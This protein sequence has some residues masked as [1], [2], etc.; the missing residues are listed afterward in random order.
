[1]PHW[2]QAIEHYSKRISHTARIDL[3]EVKDAAPKLPKNTGTEQ[4][5]ERILKHIKPS[6]VLIC[7]DETGKSMSSEQLATHLGQLYDSGKTPCF[8]I[9][10]AYGHSAEVRKRANLLLSM[11]AMTFPHELAKVILFE[12]I[13]RTETILAGTGYHHQ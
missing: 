11:G 10:G 8:C 5:G 12:Q 7:L 3:I 1:M 9:G 2:K 13:Y 6:D 4:E